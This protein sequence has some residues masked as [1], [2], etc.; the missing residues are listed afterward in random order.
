MATI[1]DFTREQFKAFLLTYSSHVDYNFSAP[2]KVL[3]EKLVPNDS[4]YLIKLFNKLEENERVQ[5]L[6]EGALKYLVSQDDI[7]DFEESLNRQFIADGKYCH[8]EKSFFKYYSNLIKS[9]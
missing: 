1:G 7:E 3:I 4:D 6:V 8:F 2:E 5:I 9:I